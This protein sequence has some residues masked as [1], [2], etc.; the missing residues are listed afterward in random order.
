MYPNARTQSPPSKLEG[1]KQ[2]GVGM[3]VAGCKDQEHRLWNRVLGDGT[4]SLLL[5]E[6]GQV[7]M[8][9]TNVLTGV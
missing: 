5:H 9:R 6:F 7:S 2:W 8:R 1:R 4:V 3:G